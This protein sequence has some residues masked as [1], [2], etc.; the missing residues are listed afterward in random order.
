MIQLP[1]IGAFLEA[2]GMILEKKILRKR[3][4]DYRNYTAYEFFA[5][6]IVMLPFA[7]LFWNIKEEALSFVNIILFLFVILISAAAN[8]L[9]FYSLKREKVT[10][11]EPIW[12]MQ[13]L[14]TIVLAFILYKTERN[15]FLILIALIASVSLVLAHVKKHHLVY[16]KYIIAALL[17]SFLFA[18]ELVLSK[19]LLP[20]YNPFAFY[21][22]R[23]TFIFLI[24]YFMF[25]PSG[26]DIDKNSA[27]IILLIGAM[28][29]IYRAII[30]YG[31]QNLGIVFT[32]I[33]FL[34]SPVLTVIF[35]IVFLKEKITIRQIVSMAV[36]LAC[37]IL[38]IYV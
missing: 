34:L 5:I 26:K 9:I 32:T 11:F 3:K 4:L 29:A 16:D 20:Y 38:S 21:F 13:P 8:L 17:G 28:W 6:F 30:Y 36:I 24:A 7:Y 15:W 23:C 27:L 12:L 18:L 10:E 22:V 31:Y 33:L 1:I 25:R 19:M 14:F 37:I 2:T 35:A